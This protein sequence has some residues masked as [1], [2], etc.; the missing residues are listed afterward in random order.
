[1]KQDPLA[2]VVFGAAL[3]LLA[4]LL[5]YVFFF[6]APEPASTAGTADFL[7]KARR[8]AAAVAEKFQDKPAA[9]ARPAAPAGIEAGRTWRY[10]VVVEPPAWRDITRTLRGAFTAG[11]A[12]RAAGPAVEL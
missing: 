10:A 3:A 12:S 4:G 2:L 6:K 11:N 1:M 7:E 5:L 9:K 8:Q